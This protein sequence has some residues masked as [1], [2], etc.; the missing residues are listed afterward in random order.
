[1]ERCV[2]DARRSLTKWGVT[3]RNEQDKIIDKLIENRFIDENRYAAAYV[4]DKI[5]T[6]RWGTGRIKLGLLQKQ[7][8]ADII[9]TTIAENIVPEEQTDQ[10]YRMLERLYAKEKDKH[11]TPY[12]LRA[13]LFNRAA[14]R[15]Y[16]IE[17]INTTI[18]QI[19]KD[20]E[21]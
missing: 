13:K 9:D 20:S 19:I 17:T 11:D 10:L 6:G 4:R 1:M 12:K 3:Q 18:N 14:Y 2:F 8:P 7:I 16:E 5:I 21:E 15:G